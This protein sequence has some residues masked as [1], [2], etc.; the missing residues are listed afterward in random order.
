MTQNIINYTLLKTIDNTITNW[1]IG[2]DKRN[3][4]IRLPLASQLI[5]NDKVWLQKTNED[6]VNWSIRYAKMVEDKTGFKLPNDFIKK[7]QSVVDNKESEYCVHVIA[8]TKHKMPETGVKLTIDSLYSDTISDTIDLYSNA[9]DTVD[10]SHLT[11]NL[12]MFPRQ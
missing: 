12:E 6:K 9:S 5:E 8:G 4:Q 2:M 7:L 1:C 10:I 11:W 3:F